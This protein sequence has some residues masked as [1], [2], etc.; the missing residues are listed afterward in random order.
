[1]SEP[2]DPTD[3]V[4]RAAAGVPAGSTVPADRAPDSTDELAE[5]LSEE[6]AG[7]IVTDDGP[8]AGGAGLSTT[9]RGSVMRSSV[10]MGAGTV[11][12]RFGGVLRGVSL[13][14]ALGA[15][16]VAD[17]FNLGNTLPNVVYILIIGGALNAVFIPELVRHMKDD[18]DEGTGYADRLI[19]LVGLVLLVVSVLAVVFAPAIVRIYATPQYTQQ[20]LDLAVSF[21]RFCLPQIFFYGVY[22]MLSQVLNAR[23]HFGA[24]MFAPVVNNVIAI[25][26]FVLFIV[27]AGPEAGADGV[28]EPSQV[29]LLGVGT[30]LGVA[31][32]ALVL[33]P[34]LRRASYVWRPRLG[35]RGAGLGVA[36]GL[37]FWTIALVLVNQIAYAVIV[38]LA[39]GVNARSE[40]DGL[41]QAGLTAYTNAHL[42]FILPHS[43]ITVSIV[44]ALLPRMSRAAHDV[45]LSD[46]GADIGGGIRMAG[47]L[48]VPAAVGLIVL[49]T[50]AGVVLF[51]YGKTSSA[52]AQV[53][54]DLASIF[55][56]G[57]LPF[58]VYYVILRGWYALEATRTAFWVTVVLNVANLAIAVPLYELV[59]ANHPGPAAL[60]ALAVGYVVAYWITVVLAWT[61][62]SRRVGGLQTAQTLR[63]LGR[64]SAAGLAMFVVML[65][66][67][68]V[69]VAHLSDTGKVV[70][71]VEIVVSGTLGTAT[72]L[73]AARLL[74]IG[75]VTD[76]LA[77]LRRRL[78][79]RG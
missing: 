34:V 59:L 53:T 77:L 12:S 55:A 73:L 3:P 51:S 14:A 21:A 63:A 16:T 52:S 32:Q 11:V 62:L 67:R 45:R 17:M 2:T 33:I 56:L 70:A 75:E 49:G 42:M 37:A 60:G 23:G 58:T 24:P 5:S 46:L 40:A 27:V 36:G 20:Q 79:V 29:A 10:V 8:S 65:A 78:P 41:T 4:V 30:T 15:G 13:A 7:D 38:R 39:T 76:V 69:L 6:L 44:A 43:V 74:R 1:V 48:I 47:S 18:G 31:L 50:Q 54:G 28:L 72:Y 25:A 9:A 66:V 68:M 26:T 22:T 64:M 57:L 19:T 61:V 71:L 35:W